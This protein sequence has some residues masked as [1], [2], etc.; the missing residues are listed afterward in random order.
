MTTKKAVLLGCGGAAVLLLICGGVLGV[1]G[2]LAI[3]ATTPAVEAAENF[4]S[5]LANDKMAEAYALTSSALKGQQSEAQ[6]AANAKKLRL[7]DYRSVIFWQRNLTNNVAELSG[8][9][10]T[11]DGGSV[12]ISLKLVQEDGKWVVLSMGGAEAGAAAAVKAP[13]APTI[14]PEEEVR[15]LVKE[16]LLDFNQGVQAGEFA[17]FRE[18]TAQPFQKQFAVEQLREVFKDFIDQKINVAT[19]AN[20]QPVFEEGPTL[21]EDGRLVVSGYYPTKPNR[22]IFKLQYAYEDPSW[23]IISINVQVKE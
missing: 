5:L 10:T 12:P 8:T 2:Y 13:Q 1:I 7:T 19:I 4:L 21:N 11:K 23:K 3:R 17:A 22:V 20:L 16:S 15:K 6:F 14:P 18:K 9:M